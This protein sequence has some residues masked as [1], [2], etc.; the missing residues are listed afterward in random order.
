[1]VKSGIDQNNSNILEASEV[2][3]TKQICFNQNTALDKVI[4]IPI[5]YNFVGSS[6][7]APY[8]TAYIDKFNKNN[9][10]GVDSIVLVCHPFISNSSGTGTFQLYNMTDNVPIGNSSITSNNTTQN[11][12]PAQESNNAY[13]SLPNHTISL[14]I[15]ITSSKSGVV[16]YPGYS[17]LYLYRR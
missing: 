10:P 14:G 13:S 16:C 1:M 9:Y 2:D 12:A 3:N 11:M 7:P 6:S 8:V 15:S 4:I 5:N 17:Y